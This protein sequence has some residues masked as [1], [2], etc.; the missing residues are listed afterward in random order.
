[1]TPSA[2]IP[3][4]FRELSVQTPRGLAYVAIWGELEANAAAPIILLHDSLG[5][6]ALWRDFPMQLAART[7]RA[8]VAYDRPGYGRSVVRR[9]RMEV[10]FV[11]AEAGEA[12]IP[13]LDALGLEQVVLFGHSVGGGMAAAAAA[14]APERVAAVI[15]ESAQAF[16]E[17]R[18]LAGIRA[19]R[20]A[21]AAPGQVER[22]G[23]YHGERARW[24]LDAWIDTWLSPEYADWSLDRDIAAVRAPLLAL[25]GDQDE[26]GSL[27]HPERF[28]GL[29]AGEGRMQVFEGIGHVPHREAPEAVLAAVTDF[30][31]A[32]T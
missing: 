22:L 26:Y 32:A 24:V 12:L 16:V 11:R 20:D 30:L 27:R 29:S 1:M 19:A 21:F 4:L 31:R 23:R 28:S 13:V 8:V 6:T 3:P 10:D 25:H 14:T 18:T 5:C 9:D 7:G 15:T 2:S 17:D